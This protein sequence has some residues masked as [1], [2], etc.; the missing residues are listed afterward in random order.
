[1][2]LKSALSL[3]LSLSPPLGHCNFI[4]RKVQALRINILDEKAPFQHLFYCASYWVKKTTK[5]TRSICAIYSV[6]P[7]LS[8]P[9]KDNL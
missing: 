2:P 9:L 4:V 7:Y 1:M 5:G 6:D 8:E 3:S